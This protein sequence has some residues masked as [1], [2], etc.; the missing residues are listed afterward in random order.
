[1]QLITINTAT[2]STSH[3]FPMYTQHSYYNR[4]LQKN[5]WKLRFNVQVTE[6]TYT[7]RLLG[8]RHLEIITPRVVVVH[9]CYNVMLR[10]TT[11][12]NGAWEKNNNNNIEQQ[13]LIKQIDRQNYTPNSRYTVSYIC[14]TLWVKKRPTIFSVYNFAK[15]W[16][17]FKI[18]SP[19]D[20][21]KHLQ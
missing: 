1:M 19:L 4:K 16:P 11:Y 6:R 15:C 21:A 20:S 8:L 14:Y 13:P 17:I 5:Q 18:L 10:R 12:E 9:H 2:T 7:I 3:T